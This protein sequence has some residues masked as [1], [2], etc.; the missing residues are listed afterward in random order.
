MR[1]KTGILMAFVL[2]GAALVTLAGCSSDQP[3]PAQR[4]GSFMDDSYLTTAVKSKLLANEGLKSFDIKVITDHQVVT[5]KGTLP[6]EAL[7]EQAITVAKSVAGV[8][9]VV[10][11]LEV[12]SN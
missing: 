11:E 8:K 9:D 3:M 4:A 6:T 5:L 10:S 7:R 2:S 12:K 1:M